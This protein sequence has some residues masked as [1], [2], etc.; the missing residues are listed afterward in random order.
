MKRVIFLL[1]II[2]GFS[3]PLWAE[4]IILSSDIPINKLDLNFAHVI[5]VN[6]IKNLEDWR[7]DVTLLHNDTGWNHY[8]DLWVV[9]DSQTG[10]EYGRRVLTHP[11]VNEQPFTRSQTGIKIPATVETVIVKAACNV[12]GFGGTE[13]SISLK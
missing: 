10:E 9:V 12:H 13:L 3:F 5:K 4:N 1:V 2:I 6:A 7:F 8:A 11:H